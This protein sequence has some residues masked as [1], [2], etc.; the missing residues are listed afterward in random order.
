[1]SKYIV[2]VPAV[3]F[4]RFARTDEYKL[5]VTVRAAKSRTEAFEKARPYVVKC[6]AQATNG[7]RFSILVGKVN[8]P[9]EYPERCFPFRMTMEEVQCELEK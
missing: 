9:A 6:L 5:R 1:M 3:Y 8:D 2:A 4:S 7:T